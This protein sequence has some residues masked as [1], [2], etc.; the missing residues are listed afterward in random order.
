MVTCFITIFLACSK[1]EEKSPDSLF[2]ILDQKKTGITFNNKLHE[3]DSLNILTY[4]YYYNGGG[5]AIGDIN[6]DGLPDIYFSGNQVSNKLY[7]NKGGMKFS[8]ITEKAGVE[9]NSAWNTG[10]S[11]V[12]VNADG[13]Q[14]IYVCQ[15]DK[16]AGQKGR[17]HLFINLGDLT[18]KES[19]QEYG[20]DFSG[21]STQAAF[22][23]F[24]RDGDLDCYLLNHSLKDSEQFRS[25]SIT[26]KIFDPA[27]GDKLL[28]N[29]QGHFIDVSE[30]AGIFRSSIGFGLGIAI[31][32]LNRDGWADIYVGNDFHENDYM[33]L[34]N[35][36]GTFR[37]VIAQATGHTSNFTMGVAIADINNDA[38]PDV[39][40]LDMK[41][42][43]EKTY[44]MAGGW[45]TFNIYEFKR[46]FGYHHQSPRN[47]LQVNQGTKNGIPL[48]SELGCQYGIEATDWSWSPLIADFNGDG[49]K[50]IF[51]SNGIERRPNDIDFVNYYS[52]ENLKNKVSGMKLINII[53]HGGAPNYLFI[54]DGENNSFKKVFV[55]DIE[56]KISNGASYSDLDRDG[57]IDIVC[58]NL[59]ATAYIIQNNT[60][61]FEYISIQ[62]K[63]VNSNPF[64][65]G[66]QITLYQNNIVQYQYLH[67]LAGFQSG[68]EPLVYFATNGQ[69]VDSVLIQWP[70]GDEQKI[71]HPKTGFQVISRGTLNPFFPTKKMGYEDTPLTVIGV[72]HENSYVDMNEEKGIH[73]VYLPS[74]PG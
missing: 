8:D 26:R 66:S 27:S 36:N 46:S 44:K 41:P 20:L 7:L 65:L 68:K 58:N 50:D 55:P 22:F 37:E 13:L 10:V 56:S 57:D 16:I 35:Q 33:Y 71:L 61:S 45:E 19:A 70:E 63:D 69:P 72:H 73:I 30:K 38:M 52:N 32:D 67:N 25:A 34:N 59:N 62:L 47:A 4:L 15:V 21:L 29:Q 11:M 53:P 48:F 1:H 60:P 39:L 54:Q 5:V 6:N 28:E 14:D 31:G 24:D 43:D 23:D 12:D 3:S 40:S 64:G 42:G 2:Q 49:Y 9:C 17:N 18:F 74:G 51:I